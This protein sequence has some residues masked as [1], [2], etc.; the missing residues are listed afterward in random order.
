MTLLLLLRPARSAVESLADPKVTTDDL[1]R[2]EGLL[3]QAIANNVSRVDVSMTIRRDVPRASPVAALLQQGGTPL[4]TWLSV[5][6]AAV[7]LLL[8]LRERHPEPTIT[9]EQIQKITDR[10]IEEARK[11]QKEPGTPPSGA[12]SSPTAPS[13]RVST[14][15]Q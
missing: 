8:A 10:A 11:R 12:P 14:D 1:R 7:T 5:L 4:A 3:E 9:P 13:G 6:L 2:L 15:D